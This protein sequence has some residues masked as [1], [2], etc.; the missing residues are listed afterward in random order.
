MK[1]STTSPM[2]S[3]HWVVVSPPQ[4]NAS[5]AAKSTEKPAHPMSTINRRRLLAMG[6]FGRL[7]DSTQIRPPT[8]SQFPPP[9]AG[10]GQGGAL[11]PGFAYRDGD[12]LQ[13][14][15]PDDL[16]SLGRPD[17]DLAQP[18]VQIL[19]VAGHGA[20]QGHHRVALHQTGL[21]GRALRLDRDDQ[22]P[23]VLVDA[24]FYC[25]RQRHLLRPDAEG[26]SL[27]PAVGPQAFHHALGHIHRDRP[28]IATAKD[29]AVHA[30][31]PSVRVDQRTS[32]E[33]GI[34]WRVRLD[35]VL[36]LASTPPA[37]RRRHG[38]DGAEGRL[39]ATRPANGENDLP[40]LEI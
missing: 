31:R 40:R 23:A 25:V 33:S 21:I 11:P 19:Q 2:S 16:E 29:P 26:G 17:L 30:D 6:W 34:P 10:E 12:L 3:N 14:S 35:Q 18:G 38:A 22:Q 9:F 13:L 5:Q 4:E 8:C 36:D 27:D 20:V 15:G 7:P 39:E 24:G 37:P 1:A 28:A 32:A